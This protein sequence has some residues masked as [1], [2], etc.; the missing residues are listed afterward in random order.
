MNIKHEQKLSQKD[1]NTSHKKV[2]KR[3][4]TP[5]ANLKFI[6]FFVI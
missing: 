4:N 3:N 1:K 2:F 6:T 5:F